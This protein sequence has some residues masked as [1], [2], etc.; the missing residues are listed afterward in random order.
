MNKRPRDHQGKSLP[1]PSQNEE[2]WNSEG[3]SNEP[4]PAVSAPKL[5]VTISIRLD[6]ESA[7]IV[8]RAA[9][10]K[11]KTLSEFVRG[12]TVREATSV[13]DQAETASIQITSAKLLSTS[14]GNRS[15]A[16]NNTTAASPN[17]PEIVLQ[18]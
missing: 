4:T 13:V 14:S 15:T 17:S 1:Q 9:R 2:Q 6:P 12:A 8:R 7:R 10:L 11:A 16:S 18:T 3:W 5:G